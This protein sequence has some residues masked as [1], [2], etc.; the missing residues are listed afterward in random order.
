MTFSRVYKIFIQ[1]KFGLV[2]FSKCLVKIFVTRPLGLVEKKSFV[3]PCLKYHSGP[4]CPTLLRPVGGQPLKRPYSCFRG[5]PPTRRP[6]CSRLLPLWKPQ[7][8]RLCR[9]EQRPTRA[10]FMGGGGR[11]RGVHGPKMLVRYL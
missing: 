4:P 3:P 6:A 10:Y 7:V 9:T 1:I 8:V 11:G 5:G 2:R